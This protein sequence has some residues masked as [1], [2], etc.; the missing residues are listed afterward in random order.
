MTDSNI[1]SPAP[2][3][4]GCLFYGCLTSVV[5]LLLAGLLAFLAVRAVRNQFNAYT[6]TKPLE[7]PRVEMTDAD[8]QALEERLKSFGSALDQGKSPEPLVLS[9]R[10]INALIARSAN[11]KELADKVHVSLKGDEVKGMVSIPLSGLGWLG[12]GRYLNGDATFKVS[13]DNGV[14]SVTAQEIRVKGVPIPEAAMSRLRQENLA[15]DAS[16]DPKSAEVIR[17]FESIQVED[18]QVTVKGR[19]AN[20]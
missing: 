20:Q 11:T 6:D 12:K 18:S 10:D 19:P 3:R 7:M 13:L 14:L 5:L 16:Q 15:K 2:K 8:F 4:R 1:P 9:E 17:K